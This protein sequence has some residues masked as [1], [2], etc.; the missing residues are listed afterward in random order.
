M[1]QNSGNNIYIT[2]ATTATSTN[3]INSLVING[4][5]LSISDGATL[6]DASGAL[7][8]VTSHSIKSAGTTGTID[9]SSNEGIVRVDAGVAGN[10]SAPIT[11]GGNGLTVNGR[12]T[13]SL[14]TPIATSAGR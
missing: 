12:G 10:I 4:G 7:L 5:D 6:T 11:T 3:S 1:D 2:K 9:F 14:T 8:F 13:L